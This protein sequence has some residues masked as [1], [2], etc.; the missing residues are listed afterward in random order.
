MQRISEEVENRKD[1]RNHGGHSHFWCRVLT[2]AA[3]PEPTPRGSI[4]H[5]RVEL[6]CAVPRA[7]IH[8]SSAVQPET[9]E[10]Q[11]FLPHRTR[12]RAEKGSLAVLTWQTFLGFC[13]I[14]ALRLQGSEHKPVQLHCSRSPLASGRAI[15]LVG[16]CCSQDRPAAPLQPSGSSNPLPQHTWTHFCPP[17]LGNL[18]TAKRWQRTCTAREVGPL[19]LN[20]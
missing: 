17:Q 3:S 11:L 15:T 8:F 18:T 6:S 2:Q 9:I 19:L 10:S 4:H 7:R 5:L 13:I 1:V 20:S 12:T 16:S 14:S